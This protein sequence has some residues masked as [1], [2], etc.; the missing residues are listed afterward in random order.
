MLVTRNIVFK[1]KATFPN[2]NNRFPVRSENLSAWKLAFRTITIHGRNGRKFFLPSL[3]LSFQFS[4]HLNFEALVVRVNV[5]IDLTLES[6]RREGHDITLPLSHCI[7]ASCI[8]NSGE[9]C[10]CRHNMEH[11]SFFKFA[12]NCLLSAYVSPNLMDK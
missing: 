8:A 12:Q 9:I 4:F 3:F 1:F 11:G 5:K 2:I 7:S 6:I 10:A